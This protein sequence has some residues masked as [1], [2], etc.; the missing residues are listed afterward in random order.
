MSGDTAHM[1]REV[2]YK[3]ARENP[4]I[5]LLLK[6]TQESQTDTTEPLLHCT[7]KWVNQ[8]LP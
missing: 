2:S 8:R 1:R 6:V 5:I 7:V 4:A 3:K